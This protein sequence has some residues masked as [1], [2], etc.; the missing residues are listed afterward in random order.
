M[1]AL[2]FVTA[3]ANAYTLSMQGNGQSADVTADSNDVLGDGKVA[4]K[5][6][7]ENN[8]VFVTLNNATLSSDNGNPVFSFKGDET[9][10]F[11]TIICKGNCSVK[12]T[13]QYANCFRFEKCIVNLNSENST[14]KLDIE[15]NSII[16]HLQDNVICYW[17]NSEGEAFTVNIK[18]NN[19]TI[20]PVFYGAGGTSTYQYLIFMY[21]NVNIETTGNNQLVQEMESLGLAYNQKL[22]NDVVVDETEWTFKKNGDIYKGNLTITSPYPINV[23]E[24]WMFPGDEDNFHPAEL[25]SGSISYDKTNKK[26]T[27]NAAKIDGF[28]TT[29]VHNLVVWLKGDNMFQNT[30]SMGASRIYFG[31]KD[32]ELSGDADAEL[33]LYCGTAGNAG[34][35]VMHNLKIGD[36]KKLTIYGGYHGIDGYSAAN[37]TLVISST[38][39]SIS[40]NNNAIYGFANVVIQSPDLK[41]ISPQGAVY[42]ATKQTFVDTND[43]DCE[44]IVIGYE[45]LF[46]FCGQ[47][48][49]ARNASDIKVSG[50]SGKAAYDKS[51]AT[52]VLHNF[53]ITNDDNTWALYPYANM[54]IHLIGTNIL[55]GSSNA[56]ET[57]YDLT[58]EGGGTLTLNSTYGSGIK[59][60]SETRTLTVQKSAV[61]D[62]TS[63]IYADAM[64]M[65]TGGMI[66]PETGEPIGSD[67]PDGNASIL[68]VNNATLKATGKDEWYPAIKGFKQLNLTQAA[69]T[70]PANASFYFGCDGGM[71]PLAGIVSSGAYVVEQVVISQTGPNTAL[72]NTA[73]SSV[74]EK[75]IENGQVVIILDG[76]K[77]NTLGAEIK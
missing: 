18:T 67:E 73:K 23:G 39:I 45:T 26:L 43:Q 7:T 47:P 52:L 37:N 72:E 35:G 31:G 62:A 9:I 32:C 25:K 44:G 29:G 49:N 54:T 36:F 57:D 22:S 20:Q 11:V 4:V 42:D 61:V 5:F 8:T 40:A 46:E 10:Q 74:A 27:L 65:C 75:R 71:D 30:S 15:G 76:R 12:T 19:T 2:L 70:A 56:I 64:L 17:G 66:D 28:L 50:A 63:G 41:V 16:I 3:A 13:N 1:T 59:I 24:T 58:I 77:Y 48:V 14:D 6:D 55:T 51:K 34:I 68:N 21:A 33:D 53:Q 69:L 38:P 60:G